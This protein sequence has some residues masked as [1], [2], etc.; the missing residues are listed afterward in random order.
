VAPDASYWHKVRRAEKHL[1][2]LNLAARRYSKRHP[3]EAILDP[4]ASCPP[5]RWVYRGKLIKE[6]GPDIA[7]IVGDIV[8][9]L[10]SALDHLASRLS[11]KRER[12]RAAF[13]I[14]WS[15]IFDH[16]ENTGEYFDRFEKAR[17]AWRTITAGIPPEPMAIIE[18][19]QPYRLPVDQRRYDPLAVLRA[20]DNIDKHQQLTVISPRMSNVHVRFSPNNW[21]GGLVYIGEHEPMENGAVVA[22]FTPEKLSRSPMGPFFGPIIESEMQVEVTG[23]A[24]IA[25][26]L[27]QLEGDLPAFDGL[28]FI[29]SYIRN[30]VISPLEPFTKTVTDGSYFTA[31]GRQTLYRRPVERAQSSISG[32][33]QISV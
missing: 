26:K 8:H 19:L 20:L 16:D 12:D 7:V 25:L 21:G 10:R 4:N 22:V 24:E 31:A 11:S 33:Y 29:I 28:A 5:K 2:E 23:T 13:P 15:P 14:Y 1:R 18:G 9:N 17:E 27:R 6:P 32:Q 3:Y 30:A